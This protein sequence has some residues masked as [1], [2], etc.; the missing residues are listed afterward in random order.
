MEVETRRYHHRV[1][2]TSPADLDV[3]ENAVNP[4]A[5]PS[6]WTSPR[7]QALAALVIAVVALLVAVAVAVVSWLW[8]SQQSTSAFTQSGDAKA[9]LCSAFTVAYKA[10][11]TSTHLANPGGNDPSGQLAVAANARVALLGGGAYLHD[12]LAAQ[13]SPPADLANAINS[14]ANTIEDLGA[15]YLGN[16]GNDQQAP[17]RKDL[18]SEI[19]QLNKLCAAK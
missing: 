9:N 10:V 15:N 16:A 19:T 14:M 17:L 18:D 2:H 4:Q 5:Y 7:W 6:W 13:S 11:K 3:N 1:S 12:R 8:P